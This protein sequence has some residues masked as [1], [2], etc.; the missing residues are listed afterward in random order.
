MAGRQIKIFLVDGVPGGIRTAEIVNWTGAVLVVPRGQLPNIASRFEA[1]RTGVYCLI[2]PDPESPT[3]DMVYVGEG[4]NVFKRLVIHSRDANKDFWTE[5]V[6]CVSKDENLT[7][8]HVRFLESR[9][10][11]LADDAGRSNIVN[12]TA[13]EGNPLPEADRSDME[14]FLEQV[15]VV[16]P[17]LGFSFLQPVPSIGEQ[18]SVVFEFNEVGTQAR[19]IEFGG[20]FVVL[21]GSTARRDGTPSWNLGCREIREELLKTGKLI[22]IPD[23]GYLEFTEDVPFRSP[24]AAVTVVAAANRS[25]PA[26]WRVQ[27]TRQTYGEWQE[28]RLPATDGD[29]TE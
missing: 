5:A 25:G 10:I 15:G 29:S 6:I 14:Y 7:K 23:T 22:P 17:V 8:S 1:T 20:E 4:D 2:G 12:G 27:G 16:F 26:N 13:P 21:K 28:S 18:P 24:S 19:A 3:R 9:L 11:Q